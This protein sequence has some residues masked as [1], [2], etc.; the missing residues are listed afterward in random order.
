MNK[1]AFY[2]VFFVFLSGCDETISGTF[3]AVGF[4]K[5][6]SYQ[7]EVKTGGV[8]AAPTLA[9]FLNGD[10]AIYVERP[11]TSLADPNCKGTGYIWVCRFSGTYNGMQLMVVEEVHAVP[12]SRHYDVYLDG[13]LIQ[14][15]TGG[16]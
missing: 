16:F 11:M 7:I 8:V 3:R 6:Q 2:L 4:H 5:N 14:R 13:Q 12:T 15:V 9:V 1:F 10:R